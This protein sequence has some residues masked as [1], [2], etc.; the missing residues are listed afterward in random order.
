MERPAQRLVH[1]T[2]MN[3]NLEEFNI[4]PFDVDTSQPSI[5]P[6]IDNISKANDHKPED[7]IPKINDMEDFNLNQNDKEDSNIPIMRSKP[8]KIQTI[9]ECPKIVDIKTIKKRIKK[10]N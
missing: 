4:D 3:D 9:T 8:I 5:L 7:E 2:N 6:E 1:I 10:Q